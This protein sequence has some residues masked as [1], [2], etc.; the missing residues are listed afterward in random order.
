MRIIPKKTLATSDTA[1][2]NSDTWL[3]RE[4]TVIPADYGNSLLS[5]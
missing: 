4:E 5:R 3:V 2:Y 1:C